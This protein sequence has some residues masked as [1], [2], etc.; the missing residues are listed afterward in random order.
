MKKVLLLG[1]CVLDRVT[2]YL[3]LTYCA[4][5]LAILPGVT[6][7]TCNNRGITWGLLAAENSGLYSVISLLVLCVAGVL[8]WQTYQAWL[9]RKSITG[10]LLILLGAGSN[11]LDR[12]L[13][14]GVVDFIQISWRSYAWPVFNVADVAIVVGVCIMIVQ[15]SLPSRYA[16]T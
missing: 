3:A 11:L 14:H 5:P 10:Q 7:I 4:E 12:V 16:Y 13:Y 1:L 2:K 15:E 8:L 6:C 9:R